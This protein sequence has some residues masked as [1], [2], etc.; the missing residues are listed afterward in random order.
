MADKSI[1]QYILIFFESVFKIIIHS[2][3]IEC[4]YRM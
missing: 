3:Q 2:I 1:C 4:G